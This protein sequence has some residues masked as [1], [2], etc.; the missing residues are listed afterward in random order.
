MDDYDRWCL[1]M[2]FVVVLLA[3]L[4]SMIGSGDDEE[5]DR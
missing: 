4:V 5:D 1:A 3:G 2:T